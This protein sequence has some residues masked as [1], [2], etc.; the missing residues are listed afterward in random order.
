M[1]SG[2]LAKIGKSEVN[3]V[4]MQERG[5]AKNQAL[6]LDTFLDAHC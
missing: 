2:E 6:F 1:K 4:F 3:G 5:S